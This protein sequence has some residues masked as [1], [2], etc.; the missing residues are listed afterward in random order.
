MQ[1]IIVLL[2]ALLF[3]AAFSFLAIYIEDCMMKKNAEEHPL[4][5]DEEF[6]S[7]WQ[8][9]KGDE[10]EFERLAAFESKVKMVETEYVLSLSMNP[11]AHRRMAILFS[12]WG[13]EW[14]REHGIQ[15]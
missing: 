3:V 4:L 15:D 1:I 6:E 5:S 7:L 10:K 8:M 13:R 11:R 12:Q 2:A 9:A 14:D